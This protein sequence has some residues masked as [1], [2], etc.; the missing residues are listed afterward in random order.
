MARCNKSFYALLGIIS[1]GE[2]SGYDIKQIM[3]KISQ[4]YWSESNA[5]IYSSLKLLEE[6]GY[7][8]SRLEESSGA[9]QCRKY[10]MTKKGQKK[11]VDWLLQPC[12]LPKY[13]E[14]LL[15]KMGLSQHLPITE[16]IKHVKHYEKNLDERLEYL[17]EIQKHIDTKHK[18]RPDKPFLKIT[19][20]QIYLVLMAKKQWAQ[21]AAKELKKL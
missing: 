5:Q 21:E 3:D 15:L 14:E 20:R 7:V 17:T 11:L 16:M 10:S 4:F 18:D 1:K 19:Y 2:V 13:R 9:R 8:V 12:E 6:G